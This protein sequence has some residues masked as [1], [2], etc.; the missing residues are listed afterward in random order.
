M[1]SSDRQ[2]KLSRIPPWLSREGFV[3]PVA[4]LLTTACLL[5]AAL[6]QAADPT[7]G[8]G[9]AG[10][11]PLVIPAAFVRSLSAIERSTIASIVDADEAE[12][13]FALR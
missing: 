5:G 7:D 13:S 8:D 2:K 9:L 1:R 3:F 12:I 6:G 11:A 4:P 10:Q